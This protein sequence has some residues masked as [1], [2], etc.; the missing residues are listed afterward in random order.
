MFYKKYA[1]HPLLAPFVECYYIWEKETK[2]EEKAFRMEI[3]SPPTGFG[4]I[5]F[6]TGTPYTVK[7]GLSGRTDQ[8]PSSFITGQSTQQYRLYL[9]GSINMTGIVFRPAGLSSLFGLPMIEFADERIALADVSGVVYRQ[10]EEQI[11][12]CRTYAARIEVIEQYL[13][14]LFMKKEIRPD[15]IDHVANLIVANKGVINL[16]QLVEESFLCRRQFERKFLQRVGVSPKYYARIRRIGYLCSVLAGQ[17]WQVK[18]WHE[19]IF[20]HGYYDQSHFI[21]EFTEFTCKAPSLYVKGNAELANYLR[22]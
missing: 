22:G 11:A 17:R 18:D 1:P 9:S 5:V 12:G 15:R 14:F 4:S 8:V 6:N 21:R 20:R 10:L 16:G 19:L 7:T 3:E 2:P 13:L